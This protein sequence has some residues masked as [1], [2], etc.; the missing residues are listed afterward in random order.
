MNIHYCLHKLKK[1]LLKLFKLR[2]LFFK[3]IFKVLFPNMFKKKTSFF[4]DKVSCKEADRSE[5]RGNVYYRIPSIVP[6]NVYLSTY[7]VITVNI[8]NALPAALA[9]TNMTIMSYYHVIQK[10][11]IHLLLF[12]LLILQFIEEYLTFFLM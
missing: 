7:I 2:T 1:I 5:M 10:T 11:F 12:L 8:T 4:Y 6:L 9:G 3:L